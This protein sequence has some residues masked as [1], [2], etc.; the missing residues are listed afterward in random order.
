MIV[1][2]LIRVANGH[3]KINQSKKLYL[4]LVL[5]QSKNQILIKELNFNKF[6]CQFNFIT[7]SSQNQMLIIHIF[8]KLIKAKI[9][10]YEIELN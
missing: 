1:E 10:V 6:C 9:F 2:S 5:K 3:N 8:A 4:G 7:F